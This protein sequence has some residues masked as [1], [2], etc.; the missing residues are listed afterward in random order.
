[1]KAACPKDYKHTKQ[2]SMSDTKLNHITQKSDE[3]TVSI[4]R[5]TTGINA[6]CYRPPF[7]E[8]VLF[9]DRDTNSDQ[10]IGTCCRR[11]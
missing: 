10:N 5:A 7:I 2:S 8:G 3:F 9:S 1:M 4:D 11:S 6:G